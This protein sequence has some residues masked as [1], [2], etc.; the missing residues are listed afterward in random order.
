[1]SE[2][3]VPKRPEKVYTWR[4]QLPPPFDKPTPIQCR[5]ASLDC[6]SR[7]Q[8]C[9]RIDPGAWNGGKPRRRNSSHD[10]LQGT[11]RCISWLRYMRRSHDARQAEKLSSAVKKLK[12]YDLD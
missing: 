2:K 7:N 5:R 1:M 12:R 9:D 6:L 8:T 4:E 3:V 11:D 10:A